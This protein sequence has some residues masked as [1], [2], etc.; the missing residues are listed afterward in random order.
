[1]G[2]SYVDGFVFATNLDPIKAVRN[3]ILMFKY[4][5]EKSWI[6]KQFYQTKNLQFLKIN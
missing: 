2:M 6:S 5:R 4:Y 3:K 1:M